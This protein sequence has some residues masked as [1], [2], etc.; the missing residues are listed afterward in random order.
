MADE[1]LSTEEISALLDRGAGEASEDGHVEECPSCRREMELLRRM[2]MA[3]SALDDREAPPGA[4][5]SVEAELEQRDVVD[6]EDG[7]ARSAAGS[8]PFSLGDVGWARAAAAVVLFVGGLGLGT[9]LASPGGGG[10]GA[11]A[12]AATAGRATVSDEPASDAGAGAEPGPS[13]TP[14]RSD[15]GSRVAVA[16]D[17]STEPAG[18]SDGLTYR[19]A[20]ERL[21]E[22]RDR[23]P[24][25]E[26]AY[27][28]PRAA[29]EHLARLDA[30]M[31]ASQEAL[32]EDPAD[33]ALNDFLFRVAEE[34]E[35][36]NRALQLSSLE[37]R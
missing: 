13:E 1:H 6:R 15:G 31:R 2:R 14:A 12:D 8:P 10:A 20:R 33:P 9:H 29:A 7:A 25:F 27:R 23:G 22:L 3:L 18:A 11:A 36:L 16:G 5:A 17:A 24:T 19:E 21:E 32:R 28:N 30:L 35:S 34:R 4:W 37:Y 26:E